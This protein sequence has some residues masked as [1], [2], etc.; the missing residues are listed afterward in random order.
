M[1]LNKWNNVAIE[2]FIAIS[3]ASQSSI[4]KHYISFVCSSNPHSYHD[5]TATVSI[6]TLYTRLE[7]TFTP[8]T[9]HSTPPV[10]FLPK[11]RLIREYNVVPLKP[12]PSHVITSPIKAHL[13]VRAVMGQIE[14]AHVYVYVECSDP[15]VGSLLDVDLVGDD[16]QMTLWC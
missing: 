7:V 14:N 3:H 10:Y 16:H 5:A 8:S 6:T 13:S 9:V 4:N 12:T 11:S 2:N 1:T 15:E